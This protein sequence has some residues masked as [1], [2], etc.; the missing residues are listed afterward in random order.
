MGVT[1]ESLWLALASL[2][3]LCVTYVWTILS[4]GVKMGKVLGPKGT[5]LSMGEEARIH[6]CDLQVA[7]VG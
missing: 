1:K 2:T 4:M 3:V 7:M 5:Q 6:P